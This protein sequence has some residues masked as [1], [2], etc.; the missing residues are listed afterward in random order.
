MYI[1]LS[2]IVLSLQIPEKNGC[3]K[4]RQLCQGYDARLGSSYLPP[5]NLK[6]NQ[7]FT[8]LK[9]CCKAKPDPK[10]IIPHFKSNVKP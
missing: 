4:M 9:L 3:G 1:N 5:V 10:I 7:P 8:I 2:A 6:E